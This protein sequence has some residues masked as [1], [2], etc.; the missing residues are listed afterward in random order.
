[1]HNY[2]IYVDDALALIA[3]R[4]RD[5]RVAA[6]SASDQATIN[7]TYSF[8]PFL[9]G[10]ISTEGGAILVEKSIYL[11]CLTP[12]RN[13]QTDVNNPVYTG[14]IL[15]TDSIYMFHETDGTLTTQRGDSTDV[16]SRMGPSQAAIIPFSWN[17]SDGSR[18][19]PAPAMDDPASLQSIIQAGA[20]AGTLTWSKDNWLK[21]TY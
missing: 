7:S 15:S 10:S 5:T 21:T 9:N 14:K 19:Y 16:G 12:L 17:T 3:K 13:N 8:N 11:D 2:N 18:P 20:G 6:M 4:L 1:V